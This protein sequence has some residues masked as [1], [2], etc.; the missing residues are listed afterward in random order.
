[1]TD[2]RRYK[3]SFLTRRLAAAHN[4]LADP[5]A[6]G[7]RRCGARKRINRTLAILVALPPIPPMKAELETDRLARK[8]REFDAKP[9]VARS[10]PA[11]HVAQVLTTAAVL[12]ARA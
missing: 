5:T 1:M 6:T 3:A 8:R 11:Q 4:V 7:A 12:A 10:R 2:R 9:P